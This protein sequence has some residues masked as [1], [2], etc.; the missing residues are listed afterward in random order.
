ME[1]PTPVS[2]LIHAATM[3]TA[4]VY[5]VV[6]MHAVFMMAPTTL[7]VI[8][9]I[10]GL[11]A[12]FAAIC[13]TAQ[14][15]LKRVLAYSTIS[16]LG[17]MFLACGIGAFYAAMFH[18]TT[19]AFMKSLLFLSAGNVVHML[20]G[21]TEMSK[22]GG[23][24]KK[25]P[26]THGLFLVGALAMSGIP[27]LAAFFSKDLILELEH[28]A[29]FDF[30][31]YIALIASVLTAFY[32]IRA[33]CLTFLGAKKFDEKTEQTPHEAPN[34]MLVPVA[35][36]AFLS[37]AGGF[38]GFAFGRVPVLESF[39]NDIGITLAEKQLTTAFVV[40]PEMLMSVGGALLGAIL[41]LV[42]YT[43]FPN[44]VG[45]SLLLFQKAFYVNEIY[46]KGIV[47]PMR[48]LSK[49][50]VGKVEPCLFEG[51]I[52]AAVAGTHRTAAWMQ[53]LQNGQIR[54]YAAWLVMGSIFLVIYTLYR[55]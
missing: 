9:T 37:I 26:V 40:S 33:Y 35:V 2:A 5:L 47:K 29:G 55:N 8:S 27:P 10:G 18:L 50:I 25:L 7:Y 52:A 36:L 23:L 16:Q 4:G 34:I 53:Q 38:L 1:G 39:L 46:D 32:L 12:C 17:L 44:R 30:L 6:R 3:V 13:A 19:H 43:R 15:D 48:G 41:A 28:L 51:S 11:T 20:H 42:I 31:F 21:T 22:M 45:N 14:S 54:S 24:A 49:F